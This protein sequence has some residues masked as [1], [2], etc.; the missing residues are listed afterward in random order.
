MIAK[1]SYSL[2]NMAD[3]KD[4]M[5]KKRCLSAERTTGSLSSQVNFFHRMIL[6]CRSRFGTL[7]LTK[8]AH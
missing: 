8:N 7:K 1:D 4:M 3:L 5:L 6:N 2:I